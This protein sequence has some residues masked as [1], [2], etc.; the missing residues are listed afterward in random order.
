MNVSQF[1]V[2]PGAAVLN[3]VAA[4]GARISVHRHGGHISSWVPAD[5]LERLYLSGRADYRKTAAIR[6][7]IP[8]IFPQFAGEGPLPKHGFARTA[9]WRFVDA[10]PVDGGG[11]ALRL[12]L[13]DDAATRALWPQAFAVELQAVIGGRQLSVVLSVQNRGAAAFAFT[14]ALHS[15]LAV[16]DLAAL[17]LLGLQGLRYRDSANGGRLCH[18]AAAELAIDGEV[19]RIY[20]DAPA[21]L[22]LREP[23]RRLRLRQSGFPDTVVWNPGAIKGAQL[24][25]LDADG[26]RRMLCVEAAV[27]GRP[28]QLAA[29]DTWTGSQTLIAG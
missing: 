18:E 14:A 15:Y 29:G 27:V 25:D 4:D 8:L 13:E 3:L 7:G 22:L 17:R 20:L 1:P 23:G 28:V 5:G 21:E 26:H 9:D 11:L 12:R 19:D 16:D 6:G 10:G 24:A 2:D